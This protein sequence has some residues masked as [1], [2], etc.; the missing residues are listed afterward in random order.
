MQETSAADRQAG[1]GM[2]TVLGYHLRRDI[3]HQ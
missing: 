3:Q 1:T 2:V